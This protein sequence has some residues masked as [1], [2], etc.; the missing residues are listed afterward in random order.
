MTRNSLVCL[1][2]LATVARAEEL[3]PGAVLRIG[4]PFLR[5]RSQVQHVAW[6]PD[7]KR[8][9]SAGLDERIKVWEP[10]NGKQVAALNSAFNEMTF[11]WSPDGKKIVSGGWNHGGGF[12]E[13]MT[14]WDVESG[15]ALLHFPLPERDSVYS[16]AYSPDGSL[17]ASGSNLGKVHLWDPARGKLLRTLEGHGSW[18]KRVVFSPDGK[19]IA[20]GGQDKL[21]L[22]WDVATGKLRTTL[23]D[24][25]GDVY[26]LCFSPDG[27]TLASGDSNDTWVRLWEVET[28]KVR[29][30][31]RGGVGYVACLAWSPDGKRLAT[32]ASSNGIVH[33][34]DV[35]SGKS[36]GKMTTESQ[37][38]RGAAFHPDGKTL[39]TAS[40]D[41]LVRLWDVETLKEKPAP[42]GHLREIVAV[43]FS[44][45]STKLITGTPDFTARIWDLKTGKEEVKA[46][47]PGQYWIS[48]VAL[49]T[50]GQ[51]LAVGGHKETQLFDAK[52]GKHVRSL[53]GQEGVAWHA[54]IS[55]DGKTLATGSNGGTIAWWDIA[56]GKKKSEE[57][58]PGYGII[59]LRYRPGGEL[60]ADALKPNILHRYSW[61]GKKDLLS[62]PMT[63]VLMKTPALSHDGRMMASVDKNGTIQLWETSTQ[64]MRLAFASDQKEEIISLAF[65]PD[66][67]RLASG[68]NDTTV[69][70][71][72]TMGTKDEVIRGLQQDLD[73]CWLKMGSHSGGESYRAIRALAGVPEKAVAF[74]DTCLK[75]VDEKTRSIAKLIADLDHTRFA[76]RERAMK[77][78]LDLG[79]VVRT[80][81]ESALE[82]KPSLE[83]RRR[84]EEILGKMP[85]QALSPFIRDLR[86]LET[87]ERIGTKEAR[88]V[89]TRIAG[90]AAEDPLT[91]EAKFTL[92]RLEN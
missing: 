54:A 76:I 1:V 15:T 87:L 89:I 11:A 59:G 48:S 64:Q 17:L 22:L 78:L 83:M 37:D 58:F 14:L 66:G 33:M 16:V 85:R 23:K 7:G 63:K 80:Q 73:S 19:L 32:C 70:I 86:A 26:Q 24:H 71:W 35:E 92:E 18:V 38:F 25:S 29:R 81:V 3:P 5:H 82:G 60:T 69:V 77:E 88:V 36:L 68:S 6:S 75:G 12:N 65:S 67:R 30:F 49:S 45:D 91:R 46:K 74:L 56:T 42:P 72:D 90:G 57:P 31:W 44:A 9:A 62:V 41:G 13:R 55:P 4:S 27:K 2:I 8:L 51:T 84:L 20:S 10:S 52:T 61:E 21:I 50:D 34:V 79:P 43:A 47:W 28:G 53:K 39:A 40:A